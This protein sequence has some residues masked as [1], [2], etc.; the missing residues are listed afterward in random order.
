MQSF[1]TFFFESHRFISYLI[2]FFSIFIEGEI[3]L[4]LAGVFSHKGYLDV[5]D[6]ML[7]ASSAAI[8]H[9][10]FYWSIGEKLLK[11]GKTKFLFIDLKKIKG[12]LE[13]S[14]IS[15]GFLIFVSKFAWSLNRIVLIATGYMKISFT[16]LWR[17]SVAAAI[18][19]SVLLVSLGYF[20]AS[21]TDILKKDFK[22][23]ALLLVG[24]IVGVII[25]E[26]ILTKTIKKS[27]IKK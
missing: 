24:L 9:D 20:F 26:N 23:A 18:S 25:L 13:E 14:S 12:F 10:L 27:V 11:T 15:S 8:L 21:K 3:I 7:V 2:I 17:Y 5:F 4:L 19:W 16:K 22:T 6:V 1:L